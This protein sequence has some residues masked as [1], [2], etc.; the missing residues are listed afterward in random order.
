MGAINS[1]RFSAFSILG[2]G[3]FMGGMESAPPIA[4]PWCLAANRAERFGALLIEAVQ[5][6]E[7][8]VGL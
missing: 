4:T 1:G 7:T 3:S 8:V 6:G 5:T 2:F